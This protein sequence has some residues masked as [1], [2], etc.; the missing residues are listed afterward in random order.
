MKHQM[1]KYLSI[2]IDVDTVSSL[3]PEHNV[4]DNTF[5]NGLERFLDIFRQFNINAT[6][7]IVGKDTHSQE[8]IE[9]L[10]KIND[11]GHEIANHTMNHEQGFYLLSK[12]HK[13]HE[14]EEN[15]KAIKNNIDVNVSGFRAPGWNIDRETIQ[16][17]SEKNYLYDSSIFPTSVMPAAKLMHYLSTR[18]LSSKS[19]RTTMGPISNMFSRS[20]IHVVSTD[21]NDLKNDICEYPLSTTSFLRFPF[22]GTIIFEYG[23]LYFKTFYRLIKNRKRVNFSLH[24]AEL[25][26]K[27]VDFDSDILNRD[28]NKGY[29]P[30]CLYMDISFKLDIFEKIFKQFLLD[31]DLLT[32]KDSVTHFLSENQ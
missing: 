32:M 16:I 28:M 5:L 14:I 1:N 10:K 15:E 26:D 18:N 17:L 20:K 31:F 13:L 11:A 24:L 4:R 3:F 21:N 29:I 2:T 25:C 19:Q 7:F 12:E 6:F 8:N 22:F 23:M 27:K 30:K 9:I